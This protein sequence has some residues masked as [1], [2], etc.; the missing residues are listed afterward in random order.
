MCLWLGA[1]GGAPRGAQGICPMSI[2]VWTQLG[3][4]AG[5]ATSLPLWPRAHSTRSPGDT[6]PRPAGCPARAQERTQQMGT[7]SVAHAWQGWRSGWG[8]YL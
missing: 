2:Q 4:G 6:W 3:A 8:M 1:E 5:G 7:C